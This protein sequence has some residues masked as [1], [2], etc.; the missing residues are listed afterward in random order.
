MTAAYLDLLH[1][2]VLTGMEG[3]SPLLLG[4]MCAWSC[5]IHLMTEKRQVKKKD[6]ENTEEGWWSREM[7]GKAGSLGSHN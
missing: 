4:T 2:P 7:E 6:K 1:S 5:S 3:N